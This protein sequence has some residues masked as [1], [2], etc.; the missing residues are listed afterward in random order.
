M[1]HELKIWPQFYCR[2]KDG[3]KTFEVRN[4][5]RNF[6]RGDMV[7]LR[8]WDPEPINKQVPMPSPKGYTESPP[9]EFEVG[10]ILVLDEKTVVFSLLPL[11]QPPKVVK[12]SQSK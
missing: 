7:V 11:K 10:Y 8:E 12:K 2:V 6:Q 4:N 9:L 5:D 3:S 1:K